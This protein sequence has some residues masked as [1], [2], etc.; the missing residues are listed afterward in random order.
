M[1]GWHCLV[2]P[3]IADEPATIEVGRSVWR[4]EAGE[5]LRPQAFTEDQVAEIRALTGPPDFETLFQQNAQGVP[6]EPLT[7]EHLPE[8]RRHIPDN[9]PLVVSID[10]AQAAHAKAS[11]WVAQAW[12]IIDDSYVLVEQMRE[13][14]G[15]NGMMA[16]LS[17]FLKRWRPSVILIEQTST[18]IAVAEQLKRKQAAT[19]VEIPVPTAAKVDRLKA[20]IGVILARRIQVAIGAPCREEFVEEV[21]GFPQ[22]ASDDQVDAMTQFLNYVAAA[23]VIRS[24]QQRA[25]AHART[26]TG[27]RASGANVE[28]YS[29]GGRAISAIGRYRRF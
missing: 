11:F 13:Q 8:F 22:A 18:G 15:Y 7:E 25:V 1:P 6:W 2:L 4:R 24:R 19:I 27:I 29:S 10:P 17:R 16:A 9:A 12:V 20:C 3:F 28:V 14:S 21:T 23:P 5:L 26:A